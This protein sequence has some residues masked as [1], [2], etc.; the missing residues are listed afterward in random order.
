M[1]S[2]EA[3]SSTMTQVESWNGS[4]WTEVAELNNNRKL[5]TIFGLTGDAATNASGSNPT[6]NN[7]TNCE[8]WNGSSWTEIA[9]VSTAVRVGTGAGSQN[10]GYKIGGYS[11]ANE[12]KTEFYNG[13]SWTEFNDLSTAREGLIGSGGTTATFVA[14][15]VDPSAVTGATEEFTISLANK[16]ITSS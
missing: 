2:G 14:G 5:A 10:L 8:Q 4:S 15:G 9:D 7:L 16:T 3:T 13:T 12:A 1:V 6:T 11:T